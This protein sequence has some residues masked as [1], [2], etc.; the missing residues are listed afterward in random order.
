MLVGGPSSVRKYIPN[1]DAAV[2][3]LHS[4]TTEPA[5]FLVVGVHAAVRSLTRLKMI[6]L[7]L[8]RPITV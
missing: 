1:L 5:A 8:H 7:V 2:M 4:N 6:F 3:R